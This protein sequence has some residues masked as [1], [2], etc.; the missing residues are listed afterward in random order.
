MVSV[1]KKYREQEAAGNG[2]APVAPEPIAPSDPVRAAEENA[3]LKEMNSLNVRLQEMERADALSRQAQQPPQP[4]PQESQQQPAMPPAVEKWLSANPQYLDPND[5]VAQAEIH[6]ATVKC[7]RD[8][9]TWD[10]PDFI[11]SLERHL[12]FMP[13]TNEQVERPVERP[14]PVP[15]PSAPSPRPAASPQRSAPVA[16]SAPPTRDVPSMSTGRPS[17]RSIALTPEETEFAKT[18]KQNP[19]EPDEVSVR[20]YAANKLKALNE[21]AIGPGSRDGR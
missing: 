5:H 21:G 14:Q 16:Y 15:R 8:G 20:R 2:A 13:A 7:M 6:L 18:C 17:N 4:E 19:E 12:G 3:R 1:P 11:P 10:A 9:K